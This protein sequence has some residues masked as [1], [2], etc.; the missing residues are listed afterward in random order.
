[1]TYFTPTTLTRD[2]LARASAVNANFQGV[3]DGFAKLPPDTAFSLHRFNYAADTGAANAYIVT[4]S[5]VPGSYAVGLTIDMLAANANTGA[6]TINVNSLGPKQILDGGGSPLIAGMIPTSRVVTLKY[7]GTAFRL[8]A[9]ATTTVPEDGS[10]TGAKM[11]SGDA[12]AI[13]AAIGTVIGT[14]V[15]AYDADLQ[16]IAGLTSASN[17]FIYY[18]GS[19]AAALGD[20]TA[21]MRA[22]LALTPATD[23]YITFSDANTA[24]M[25]TITAGARSALALTPEADRLVYF[26]GASTAA[27]ATIT[28]AGRALIDDADAAAQ[29]VTLGTNVTLGTSVASTSGTAIDFTG[30]PAGVNRIT[31]MFVGV[32]TNGTSVPIVQLGDAGGIEATGYLGAASAITTTTVGSAN[33]TTGIGL[34]S[35][36]SDTIV[37]HGPLTLTRQTGN[38]WVSSHVFGRNDAAGTALGG[39]SKTLSAE[40]DRVR[41]TTVGGTDTFDAGAVNIAWEF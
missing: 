38:T 23:R 27:L 25:S 8:G 26:S 4:L 32:S 6:S 2:T 39:A 41:L 13:R 31:I 19:A 28:A 29:R 11:A 21:G 24:V 16:A 33:Y 18:T 15:Q 10:V 36:M 17:K 3:V 5:P 7:D 22:A 35:S 9:L 30:I 34:I 12:T 20:I 1:M 40:L 37:L 14:D